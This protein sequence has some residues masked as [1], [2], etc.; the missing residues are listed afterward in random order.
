M[1]I[2]APVPETSRSAP[3]TTISR[4]Q[5]VVTAPAIGK[6]FKATLLEHDKCLP[7]PKDQ[8]GRKMLGRRHIGRAA[9]EVDY[10]E[11]SVAFASRYAASEMGSMRTSSHRY[12][13]RGQY[14]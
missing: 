13:P 14:E 7:K 9:L 11:R 4:P 10:A 6:R 1:A 12:S 8:Q 5:P 2:P 3:A